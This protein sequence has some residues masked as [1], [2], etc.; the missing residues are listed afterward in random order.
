[1]VSRTMR[2]A[3]PYSVKSEEKLQLL[4][5]RR[6]TM[7]KK[8]QKG[9]TVAPSSRSRSP[10]QHASPT[11]LP[12]TSVV[13]FGAASS[14]E[15][16]KGSMWLASRYR[17]RLESRSGCQAL[18]S[19]CQSALSTSNSPSCPSRLQVHVARTSYIVGKGQLSHRCSFAH[20][21]AGR[22]LNRLCLLQ[23]RIK[24]WNWYASQSVAASMPLRS[25]H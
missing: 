23:P 25:Q 7:P 12:S 6:P 9:P 2:F 20:R 11:R 18:L 5:A 8:L 1:M 14:R 19:I 16:L 17:F 24:C 13:Q 3:A 10:A 21:P 4:Y 15:V 22:V